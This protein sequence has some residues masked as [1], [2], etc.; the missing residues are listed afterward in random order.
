[1]PTEIKLWQIEDNKPKH[2]QQGRLDLE[3]RLED[4]LRD[5]IGL[6]NNGLLVIGQQVPTEHTGDIDL[7]AIDSD[8]NLVILE[9]KGDR[10]PRIVQ[11]LGTDCYWRLTLLVLGATIGA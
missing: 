6:V 11:L 7:L 2:I 8:A 1:M 3:S 9:L 4:W 5:D 10:T